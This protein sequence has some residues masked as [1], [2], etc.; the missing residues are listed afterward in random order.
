M[1][2]HAGHLRR[3]SARTAPAKPAAGG[4]A[5]DRAALRA[6]RSR[7]VWPALVAAVLL[8]VAGALTAIEVISALVGSPMKLIDYPR[9]T[10]WAAG[11]GG[12]WNAWGPLAIASALA[13]LG[14]IFLF[15]GLVP[16]RSRLVPLRGDSRDLVL[17]VT[18]R[19]FTGAVSAAAM[20][21]DGVTGVRKVKL[22]RHKVVVRAETGMRS[23]GDL[24]ERV[25]EAVERSLE[26]LGPLPDRDVKVRIAHREG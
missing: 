9:V 8:V 16:G 22:R 4:R 10:R 25:R 13:L 14:L 3:S 7:R 6:F 20:E 24:E 21:T 5:A 11:G 23:P 12:A 17:G 1:T 18:R 15:A 26:R 19:G 2:T